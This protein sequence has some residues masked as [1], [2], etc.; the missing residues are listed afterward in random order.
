MTF[1][2]DGG[3]PLCASFTVTARAYE[4]GTDGLGNLK[5]PFASTSEGVG[6]V[7]VYLDDAIEDGFFERR[8]ITAHGYFILTHGWA[9]QHVAE[10]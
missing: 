4:R 2:V 8:G 5:E 1:A 6:G 10:E 9:K 7:V 3:C